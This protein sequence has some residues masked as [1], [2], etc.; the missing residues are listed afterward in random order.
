MLLLKLSCVYKTPESCSNVSGSLGLEWVQ[1]FTSLA[2]SPMLTLLIQRPHFEYQGIRG[3]S[4]MNGSI[5]G[6]HVTGNT[7]GNTLC[8]RAGMFSLLQCAGEFYVMKNYPT[9]D[10]SSSFFKG[11][12]HAFRPDRIHV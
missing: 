4:E 11:R 12:S 6:C 5:F 8:W 9:Q 7:P 1:P 10:T 3:C 2:I